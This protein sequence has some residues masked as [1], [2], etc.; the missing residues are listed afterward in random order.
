L[1]HIR[2][3]DKGVCDFAFAM[4]HP[5]NT[6]NLKV[7]IEGRTNPIERKSYTFLKRRKDPAHTAPSLGAPDPRG[8]LLKAL[9]MPYS[10]IASYWRFAM[11]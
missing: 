5:L 9:L 7:S 4:L 1:N 8:Q 3:H 6:T 11:N 10:E 2:I